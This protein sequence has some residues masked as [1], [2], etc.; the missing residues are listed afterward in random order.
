MSQANKRM[1]QKSAI[2]SAALTTGGKLP[3]QQANRFIDYMMDDSVLLKEIT[4]IRMTSDTY[5]LDDIGVS[6]R[7]I[8]KGV[9]AT[10]P[11]ETAGVSTGRRQLQVTEV[12]L[13]FDIGFQFIEDNIEKQG[14]EDHVARLFAQQFGNDIEDLGINGDVDA[15]TDPD[16]DFLTIDN[17][18]I[19]IAKT[20]AKTN[21]YDTAGSTDYKGVVFPAIL[22]AMPDKWKRNRAGLA[23]LVSPGVEEEYRLSL[24]T[25]ETALGDQQLTEAATQRFAGIRVLP[26]PAWPDD[27]IVLTPVKNLAYG[28]H[29]REIRVGKQVQERKR[30]VEYTTT[31]R[32]DF[33]WIQPEAV[34]IGYDMQP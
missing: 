21:K 19:K 17:G 27:V 15:T 33:E 31:A 7:I 3:P 24:A 22:K 13:P 12:I 4:T 18:W 29:E 14:G 28:I 1:L 8:R 11:T 10:A 16:A 23:F 5:R 30:L 6:K 34:V 32:V 2:T 9:E 25:R 26:V 20:D